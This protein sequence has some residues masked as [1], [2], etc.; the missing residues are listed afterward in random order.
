MTA[1]DMRAVWYERQGPAREVLQTGRMA[2]PQPGPPSP[3]CTAPCAMP[4]A[5]GAARS[6]CWITTGVTAFTE[7]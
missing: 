4:R 1:D 2:R 5:P 7:P 3:T 6:T